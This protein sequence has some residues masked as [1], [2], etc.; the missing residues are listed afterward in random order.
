MPNKIT[1]QEEWDRLSIRQMLKYPPE[2][3]GDNIIIDSEAL[4]N[5]GK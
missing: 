5:A 1:K 4:E 2:M 3:I